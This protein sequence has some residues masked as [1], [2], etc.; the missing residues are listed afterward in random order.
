MLAF[1]GE[2][3]SLASTFPL[4]ASSSSLNLACLLYS[5][6]D[7]SRV[8]PLQPPVQAHVK[9][10]FPLTVFPFVVLPLT[11]LALPVAFGMVEDNQI[12]IIRFALCREVAFTNNVNLNLLR[13]SIRS[14]LNLIE[15]YQHDVSS[16]VLAFNRG[17]HPVAQS[18]SEKHMVLNTS[19]MV[20][21]SEVIV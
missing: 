18:I 8:R 17:E 11:F 19:L 1:W 6:S 20:L 7:N 9:V 12:I 13:Q 3:K 15:V 21:K 5:A 14:D 2:S 4:L 10:G 16:N